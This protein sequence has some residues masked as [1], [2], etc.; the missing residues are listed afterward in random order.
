MQEI[1]NKLVAISKEAYDKCLENEDNNCENCPLF[2]PIISTELYE[3]S[4][5]NMLDW[6]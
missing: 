3:F 6:F 4:I 1:I 5:C 2:K